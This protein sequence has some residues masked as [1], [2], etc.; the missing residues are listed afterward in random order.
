[1]SSDSLTI[2]DQYGRPIDPDRRRSD[3]A[4]GQMAVPT[5]IQAQGILRGGFRS[6]ISEKHD[7]ALREN[8]DNA[9]AMYRDTLVRAWLQERYNGVLGLKWRVEV[10]NPRDRW[11]RM[12]RDG[13]TRALK[14]IP[15]FRRY[16]AHLLRA[17]WFGRYANQQVW[18]WR[19]I[20]SVDEDGKPAKLN[21][22]CVDRHQP[23]HGDSLDFQFD[24]TPLLRV[25]AGVAEEAVLGRPEFTQTSLGRAVV[26]KGGFRERFTIHTYNPEP[27]DWYEPEAAGGIHG[28]GLRALLYWYWW[29]R[30]ETLSQILDFLERIGLGIVVLYYEQ[31]NP[32]SEAQ[33]NRI[34]G[35]YGRKTVV[36]MPR[37]AGTLQSRVA[38]GPNGI[39]VVE[40][41]VAGIE[42]LQALRKSFEEAME[43]LCLGQFLSSGKDDEG[44]LGGTGRAQIAADT[45]YQ[46]IAGDAEDM[47][48]T[49]TG[50]D[51]EPGPLSVMMKWTYQKYRFD[52]PVR[53][54][55]A[56][57]DEDPKAKLEAAKVIFDMGA[58]IPE[59]QV[60]AAAGLGKPQDG[61][62]VLK[63]QEGIPGMG[64]PPGAPGAAP[65]PQPGGKPAN[66]QPP[67][68]PGGAGGWKLDKVAPRGG[69]VWRNA[70]GKTASGKEPP[71]RGRKA[72]LASLAGGGEG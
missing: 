12:A 20:S 23:V 28:V 39:E 64:G 57:E 53:Y 49:L 19:E 47:D 9:Q 58:E 25:S 41:P 5:I 8:R 37:P 70:E 66:G 46:L 65:P 67:Q 51:R 34:A 55:T 30:D 31:G 40:A 48:E 56:V 38:A 7:E 59:D 16:R 72:F 3:Y 22:F 44:S 21:A 62:R 24:G 50:S 54:V 52:F 4:D 60:V 26:L 63:K 2:L 18:R 43:R 6:F 68:Q 15:R 42:V 13:M 32:E 71:Q 29:Y 14:A 61:E 11:Q 36:L 45:K 27:P 10:D 1:M 35:S 69:R 33:A 17:V